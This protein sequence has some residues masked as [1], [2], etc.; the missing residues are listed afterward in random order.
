MN[1]LTAES[2]EDALRELGKLFG[3][4][5]KCRAALANRYDK[6]LAWKEPYTQEP[7]WPEEYGE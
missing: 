6:D 1:D 2:V 4:G 3:P 7:D 5:G